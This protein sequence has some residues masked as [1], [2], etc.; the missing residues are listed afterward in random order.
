MD[1]NSD[2]ESK[3]RFYWVEGVSR[4]E[5]R[6]QLEDRRPSALR[7]QG[8]RR[9]L[10]GLCVALLVAL[11]ASTFLRVPALGATL[12][13]AA[14]SPNNWLTLDALEFAL[15]MAAIVVWLQVRKSVRFVSDAP[16]ELLDERQLAMRNAA[17][18]VAYRWMSTFAVLFMLLIMALA[19][20][21]VMPEVIRE[22]VRERSWSGL[23]MSFLLTIVSL[24]AMVLA[25]QLP[26]EPQNEAD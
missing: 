7:R 20:G 9:V 4:Q 13:K 3:D 23:H 22:T 19:D 25:W 6:T 2:K 26:S 14:A 8:P 21:G 12:M 11:F 18:V 17:Y 15:L 5:V 10:V 16:D 24:P 1:T